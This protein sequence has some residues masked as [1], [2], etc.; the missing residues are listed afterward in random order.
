MQ[1]ELHTNSACQE[2]LL[3]SHAARTPGITGYAHHPPPPS[4]R[5]HT[6]SCV[7]NLR[8][9]AYS[10]NKQVLNTFSGQAIYLLL[11][12]GNEQGKVV[13]ACVNGLSLHI[14]YH[15]LSR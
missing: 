10:S 5:A 2:C 4:G 9:F 6:S 3:S 14:D 11:G 15:T 13:P 12:H 8:L 7:S 1:P